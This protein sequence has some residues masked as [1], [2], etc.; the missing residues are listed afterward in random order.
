MSRTQICA[1]LRL[2][3]PALA[4][5]VVARADQASVLESVDSGSF[6]LVGHDRPVAQLTHG[7]AHK[8][9]LPW[10]GNGGRRSAARLVGAWAEI[11]KEPAGVPTLAYRARLIQVEI[12]EQ[13]FVG[14]T[15]SLR[16]DPAVR[17][18]HIA[19]AEEL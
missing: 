19:A 11:D 14:A 3:T 9:V 8:V 2:E 6:H 13:R 16:H 15:T 4:V 17:T 18:A 10:T 7:N 12:D 5:L 1:H